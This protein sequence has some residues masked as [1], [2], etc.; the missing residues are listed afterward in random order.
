MLFV[1]ANAWL[2]KKA[3]SKRQKLR[4]FNRREGGGKWLFNYALNTFYLRLYGFKHMIKDHSNSE[5]GNTLHPRG[6]LFP[7]SSKDSY[8]CFITHTTAFVTAVMKHWLERE[9]AQWVHYDIL[10]VFISSS[11]YKDSLGTQSTPP[12][13]L[14][15]VTPMYD[16]LLSREGMR[17]CFN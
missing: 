7:I 13:F 16:I 4:Y 6:I 17:K 2:I 12:S 1:S 9:I 3:I 8:I 10:I 11:R 15:H 5:R 14:E